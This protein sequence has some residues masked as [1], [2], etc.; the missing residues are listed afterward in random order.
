MANILEFT[1]GDRITRVQPAKPLS[2][3]GFPFEMGGDRS[4]MGEEFIFV[5]IANGQIY[6]QRSE[7]SFEYQIFGDKLIDLD[8]DLWDEGWEKWVDPKMFLN[9]DVSMIIDIKTLQIR[10]KQAIANEDYE[11][12]E[13]ISKQMKK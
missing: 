13:K 11:L 8:I 2:S 9:D 6:L 3:V 4:Y 1:K 5:G 7:T 12:A 10:L